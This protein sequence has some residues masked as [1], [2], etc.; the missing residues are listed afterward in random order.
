MGLIQ[1]FRKSLKWL[2]GS[3]LVLVF[4]LQGT[5]LINLSLLTSLEG[6]AADLRLISTLK[7]GVDPR[8]VI[9]DIDERS[10]GKYGQWP[11]NRHH[12]AQLVN[13]LFDH[14]H[15]RVMGSD[16][17]FAEPAGID[18]VPLEKEFKIRNDVSSQAKKALAFEALQDEALAQALKNRAVTLGIFF[19]QT[20]ASTLNT[21]PKPITQLENATHQALSLPKPLGYT[22]NLERFNQASPRS[23][24]FDN[25]VVDL[26]GRFRRVPL[27]QSYQGQLF[28]SLAL[29]VAQQALGN[30]EI[31]IQLVSQ[32]EFLA[33]TAI[34]LGHR[35]IATDQSG[36]V[37]IPFR[38]PEGS[39]PYISIADILDHNIELEALEDKIILL[40]T[41]APGLLDLRA[42]PV[43]ESM[44]G[45]EVHAN[46]I[47]GIL[48][49][50]IPQQPA[51]LIAVQSIGYLLLGL[52]LLILPHYLS[53]LS[54]L[55]LCSGLVVSSLVTNILLWQ[56]GLMFPLATPIL[57]IISFFIFHMSWGFFVESR[58]KRAITRLFGQYVP[59]QLV[60]EMA[61]NPEQIT[62][63]GQS[64]ELTVLFADVRNFTNIS[65]AISP[66]ELTH[67]MNQILTPMTEAIYRNMGTVDKYMGDAIMA[68]WG[69]PVEQPDH[70][71]RAVLS[72]LGMQKK[73][74]RLSDQL[75][76]KGHPE[77]AIGIG[78]N[79]GI[80]SVGN[81]GSQYRM[82]YSVMGDA[83]NLG[84]RLEGLSKVYGARIIVSEACQRQAPDFLYRTLD[85]VRVK[86]KKEPIRILEPMARLQRCSTDDIRKASLLNEAIERYCEKRW[87]MAISL[88]DQIAEYDDNDYKK[89]TF[90]YRQRIKDF[91]SNPPADDWD[92][93]FTFTE[94]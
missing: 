38:G 18:F 31:D 30:P 66:Q 28:P 53:P 68:F 37:Q 3:T 17:V 47:A 88:L 86:G 67:L 12:L 29:S 63:D 75:Q 80:M 10:L 94:K 36:A 35:I 57:L 23:G 25:P 4:F 2:L 42:T 93:V 51:Y 64:K 43:D 32:G 69:A 24:F 50:N 39:F 85:K 90:L 81:M 79:T 61:K 16:I 34:Q 15:I 82:A 1:G 49:Q 73:I 6:N 87:P 65:E 59:P 83:V 11:W 20:I 45:V 41:S 46:I 89:I 14:Y 13:T 76:A 22:A 60:A 91:Q 55:I 74:K 58:H 19:N 40:G 84:S 5:G 26:D 52:I 7:G 92:C 62:L 27:F 33:I 48:D 8:I 78:I 21:L 70:A 71:A 44:P 56:Q 72:A 77:I 9:V 54:T